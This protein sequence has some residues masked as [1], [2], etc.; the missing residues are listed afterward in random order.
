M[1]SVLCDKKY[2]ELLA[3]FGSTRKLTFGLLIG[4]KVAN[5]KDYII[6]LAKTPHS[7]SSNKSDDEEIIEIEKVTDIDSKQLAEHAL[8]ALRMTVGGFNILG[9]FVVSENNIFGD[10]QSLQK[11]K[12]VLMDIKSTLDSNGLLFANT[13]KLDDGNKLILNYVTGH[14]NFVCKTISTDPSKAPS[15]TP[16]DWKFFGKTTDWYEFE[17][18]FEVDT[19]FPLPH[20]NNHFDTEKYIMETI[21]KISDNLS[22]STMFFNEQ[23]QDEE[24]TVEKLMKINEEES[25][26][27]VTVYSDASKLAAND[28]GVLK[29]L[30]SLVR[31]TGINMIIFKSLN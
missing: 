30:E 25:K 20:T 7:D 19:V 9:M 14:K 26:I 11:L 5:G 17:T 6:H 23:P 22:Q 15:T 18:L 12:T 13:D 27:K 16:V 2:E 24:L 8:N 29:P 3:R 10:N 21:N 28:D 1:R 31:Y 4:Q